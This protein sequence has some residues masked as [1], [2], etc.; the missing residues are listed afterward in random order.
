MN[1]EDITQPTNLPP[2]TGGEHVETFLSGDK[3]LSENL[4]GLWLDFTRP[5]TPPRWTLTMND[6]NLAPIGGVGCV[7]GLSGHGKST[8]LSIIC[9]TILGGSFGR[10]RFAQAGEIERPVVLLVDTEQEIDNVIAFKN[11]VCSL[12]GRGIQEESLI[13]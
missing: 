12:I 11:R 9:A 3:W 1:P 4:T 10:M 7:G 2:L 6:T 8:F 13:L 5:Y